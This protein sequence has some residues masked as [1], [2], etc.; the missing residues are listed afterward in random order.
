M[1]FA[2]TAV[3]FSPGR[4]IEI[5]NLPV[6][7]LQYGEILVQNEYATLCRSDLNT[8]CGKRHEK[9]PTILGHEV[10]GRI[11]A[12]GPGAPEHDLRQRRL[13]PGQ[14][15]SWAIFAADP[16][17]EMSRRGIPQKSPDLFKYG[18]EQLQDNNS[19]HGGLSQYTILRAHTPVLV[20]DEKVPLPV[21][22]LINCAV[23]T[24]SGA[25]R[26]A[27]AI[28]GKN[29]LVSGAGMLGLI[30]CA[31]LKSA[32]AKHVYAFDIDAGRLETARR[33]GADA[34]FMANS[35]TEPDIS[36]DIHLEL[37]GAVEAME[38]C[39]DWMAVGATVVW[40]G[41]TY[42]QAKTGVNAEQVVRRL[43]TIRGLHNYN[44]EDFLKALEFI[45]QHYNSFPLLELVYDGF[46]LRQADEAF[47]FGLRDNP[48]RVG[49]RIE[50]NEG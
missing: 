40:V 24:V 19:L 35:G 10:V 43:L 17:S 13:E 7:D 30:A 28:E 5:H 12:L 21:A 15:L 25:L 4:A 47:Q 33:F 23:A 36:F 1:Q 27:G 42:P 14:R 48:F 44:T 3:F 46:S 29:A 20:L 9:T 2:E 22:A 11:A 45:E 16:A 50:Q 34:V 41:A 18:H 31:M 32:G 26:L 6:P 38:R 39:L 8:Y 37:S 49:L